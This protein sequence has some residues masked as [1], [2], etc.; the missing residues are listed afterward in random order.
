MAH[1]HGI[2]PG[3][4][5]TLTDKAEWEEQA[6]APSTDPRCSCCDAILVDKELKASLIHQCYDESPDDYDE[7][8]DARI[9]IYCR[10]FFGI[11]VPFGGSTRDRPDDVKKKFA[12]ITEGAEWAMLLMHQTFAT[13]GGQSVTVERGDVF[14]II[15]NGRGD[16]PSELPS[17]DRSMKSFT[18]DVALGPVT[19]T[20]FSHEFAPQH[21]AYILS[22]VADGEMEVKYL[23]QEDSIGYYTP[24]E[25]VREQIKAMFG[26][27]QPR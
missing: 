8:E 2:K 14:K 23:C 20:V 1:I 10:K 3:L 6:A 9:C 17:H 21:Q 24:T 27:F 19:L 13:P 12:Q 25:A 22:L 16:W 15:R 7:D 26:N 4:I 11:G 18:I 5:P